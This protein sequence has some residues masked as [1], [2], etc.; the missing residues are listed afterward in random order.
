MLFP[1][2]R[3]VL[4]CALFAVVCGADVVGSNFVANSLERAGGSYQGSHDGAASVSRSRGPQPSVPPQRVI[5][6]I[7]IVAVGYWL[8]YRYDGWRR[9][10]AG[11]LIFV[12]LCV[13]FVGLR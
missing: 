5:L 2:V 13:L 6:S 9:A 3:L 8:V 1:L 12:G 4:L 11:L 7:V 10:V